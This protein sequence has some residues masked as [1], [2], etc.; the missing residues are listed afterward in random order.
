MTEENSKKFPA[1]VV[2]IID[3]FTIAINRGS[4]DGVVLNQ[5]FLVYFLSDEEI[6]DPET[7]EVLGCLEIIRGKGEVIHVQERLSTIKS[8]KTT[9][10]IRRSIKRKPSSL[11]AYVEHIEQEE[12]DESGELLPFEGANVGDK[13]KPI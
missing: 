10:P 4:M 12:I 3:E 7:R 1:T 8:I 9:S 2:K 5:K 6:I 11:W 13:A